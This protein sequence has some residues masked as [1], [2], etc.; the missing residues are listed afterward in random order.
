MTM[1]ERFEAWVKTFRA[2][3]NFAYS[4]EFGCYDDNDI[5]QMYEAYQAALEPV[6]EL[7]GQWRQDACDTERFN[8]MWEAERMRHCANELAKLLED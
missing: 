2:E 7:V 1:R 3:P 4:A 6:R 5:D 8:S